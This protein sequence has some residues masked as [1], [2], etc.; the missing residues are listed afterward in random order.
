MTHTVTWE[1]GQCATGNYVLLSGVVQGDRKPPSKKQK[2][3][4]FYEWLGKGV[5]ATENV[6]T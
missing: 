4:F 6:K 5:K 2:E 3:S 1:E